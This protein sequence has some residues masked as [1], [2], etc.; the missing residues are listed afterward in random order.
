MYFYSFVFIKWKKKK[1]SHSVLILWWNLITMLKTKL[2]IPDPPS[3]ILFFQGKIDKLRNYS[4]LPPHSFNICALT[5]VLKTVLKHK[6]SLLE[7]QVSWKAGGLRMHVYSLRYALT[8]GISPFFYSPS[9]LL[10]YFFLPSIT[11]YL[12]IY[13]FLPKRNL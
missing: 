3:K 9:T 11:F 13:I 7:L 6:V 10:T 4:A 1:E 8:S 5:S 2:C 12:L